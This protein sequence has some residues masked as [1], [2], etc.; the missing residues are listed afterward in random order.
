MSEL[1]NLE[2]IQRLLN[3]MDED[4]LTKE[5][6]K[7]AFDKVM[8]YVK[9]IEQNH[10]THLERLQGLLTEATEKL[11]SDIENKAQVSKED[12][13]KMMDSVQSQL[14]KD[15]ETIQ[16]RLMEVRDG[17]DADEDLVVDRAA[18]RVKEELFIPTTE[19]LMNDVP[20]LAE[21][22]RDA[23]ELLQDDE[24][25]DVSAIKGI[26]ELLQDVD[27]KIGKAVGAI[28]VPSPVG[29]TKHQSISASSGTTVYS[30][31]EA[32]GHQGKAAIVRYEGQ[33]LT[34]TTHYS[35]SGTDITLTFDPDNGTKLD[36]TYWP[37]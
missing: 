7:S 16:T 10:K 14:E 23:L 4:A 25:L 1:Q 22:V 3:L 5:Q 30:L 8:T 37:F 36:V 2:K 17:V 12:L 24:R 13:T 35:I 6:F 28:S 11:S 21:R 20:S 27:G 34:E 9:Q 29:W 26:E 33:V 15:R 32:P 31:T 18:E 19:D